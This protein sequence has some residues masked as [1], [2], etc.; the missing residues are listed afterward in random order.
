MASGSP[1]GVP[2]AP[3]LRSWLLRDSD[4]SVR[5]RVL[6]ELLDRRE[7]DPQVVAARSAI[8]RTGWAAELLALQLPG[9]QW[10]T[11]RST[12]R[13]MEGPKYLATR[14][15]LHLLADLGMDRSDPRVAR[16]TRLYLD[17]MSGPRFNEMGGKDSEVCCTGGDVRIATRL[18]FGDDQRVTRS[19]EWLL[20]AQKK[21]GGWHCWPSR[22]GTLESWAALGAFAAIP[23]ERRSPAM[24]RSIERGLAF[25]LDRE[26]MDE[27]D[28]PYAPWLRLHFPVHYYYDV[29]VGLDLATALGKGDDP[30]L[31][32]ALDWLEG[33]RNP[34]GSWN[35]DALHPD[36]EEDA[37]LEG[38][39]TPFFPLGVEFPGRPSRWITVTALK[40]LYRAGRL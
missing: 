6:R 28:L 31:T 23:D 27:G 7:S 15:V 39:G 10:G 16:A 25:Y 22:S 29:L 3:A 38:L 37:Y 40:V 13:D 36:V 14:Y 19:I 24:R 17:R 4:P 26:L 1:R 9:G 34:D 2:L 35:L 8:G 12:P 18:G 20:A 33:R 32:R 30:R 21:D 11:P 5:Y